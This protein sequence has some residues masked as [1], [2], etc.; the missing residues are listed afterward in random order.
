MRTFDAIRLL[1]DI[2]FT[3][4]EPL[5]RCHKLRERSLILRGEGVEDICEGEPNSQREGD[6]KYRG[7]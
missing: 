1:Y 5:P 7:L 6:E 4:M 3:Q 2:M